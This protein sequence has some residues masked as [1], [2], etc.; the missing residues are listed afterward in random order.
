MDFY[1]SF[2]FINFSINSFPLFLYFQ[3]LN[4]LELASHLEKKATQLC[5]KGLG[6]IKMALVGTNTSSPLEIL[7]ESFGHVNLDTSASSV[8]TE[9][10]A[11]KSTTAEKTPEKTSEVPEKHQSPLLMMVVWHLQTLYSPC[12]CWSS[13]S[14][15]PLHGPDTFSCYQCQFLACTQEFSQKKNSCL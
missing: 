7:E 8:S 6:R 4:L 13:K 14:F 11:Q 12:H 15:L 2:H 1:L 10:S 5:H 9:E 3:G